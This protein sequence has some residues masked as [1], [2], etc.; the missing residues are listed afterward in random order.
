MP[1]IYQSIFA[2]LITKKILTQINLI[3]IHFYLNIIMIKERQI[4]DGSQV[5]CRSV[6][7][8]RRSED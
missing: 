8:R 5:D 1:N 7:A 6:P 3:L 2:K 4:C